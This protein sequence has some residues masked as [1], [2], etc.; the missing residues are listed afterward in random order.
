M[1]KLGAECGTMLA[2]SLRA[3]DNPLRDKLVPLNRRY[4]IE[5]LSQEG[6]VELQDFRGK[7]LDRDVL[8]RIDPVSAP[9]SRELARTIG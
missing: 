9:D 8:A 3:T 2:V 7:R 5:Q 6:E 1:A 4:P